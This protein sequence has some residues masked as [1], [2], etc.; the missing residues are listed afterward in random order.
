MSEDSDVPELLRP[1]PRDP[2]AVVF[3]ACLPLSLTETEI[4]V[5]SNEPSVPSRCPKT[6]LGPEWAIRSLPVPEDP[7]WNRIALASLGPKPL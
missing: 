7:V 6:P 1:L 4:T 3:Q 2:K 5:W